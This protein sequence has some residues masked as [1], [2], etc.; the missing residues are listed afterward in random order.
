VQVAQFAAGFDAELVD[1]RPSD[2]LVGRERLGLT[3]AAVQA[4]HH[5]AMNT[6]AEWMLG[7]ERLELANDLGMTAGGKIGVDPLFDRR[8]PHLLEPRDLSAGEWD[9]GKVLQRFAS[10]QCRGILE[11]SGSR[12]PITPLQRLPSAIDEGLESIE[13]QLIVLNFQ[14]ITRGLGHQPRFIPV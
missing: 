11:G 9:R 8:Q 12:G 1:E 5:R 6:L 14:Q 3:A 13:V 10:E 2:R 4:Q 7:G